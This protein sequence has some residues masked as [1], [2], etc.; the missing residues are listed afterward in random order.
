[1]PQMD[2]AGHQLKDEVFDEVYDKVQDEVDAGGYRVYRG[3]Q[4]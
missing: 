1:M 2:T 3:L 4:A